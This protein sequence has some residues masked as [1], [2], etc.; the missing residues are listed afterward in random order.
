[1]KIKYSS[2][3]IFMCLLTFLYK[4]RATQIFKLFLQKNVYF[5][6]FHINI[7]N[8]ALMSWLINNWNISQHLYDIFV[9]F[10]YSFYLYWNSLDVSRDIWV[11]FYW[12]HRM[13]FLLDWKALYSIVMPRT[14]QECDEN[15]KLIFCFHFIALQCK[16]NQLILDINNCMQNI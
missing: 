5:C 12:M 11:D 8:V 3:L 6:C 1:M 14:L 7:N 2:I 16:Y 15:I 4:V 10:C 9:L 13:H